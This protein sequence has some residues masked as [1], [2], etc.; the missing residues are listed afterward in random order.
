MDMIRSRRAPIMSTIFEGKVPVEIKKNDKGQWYGFSFDNPAENA[1]VAED[2]YPKYLALHN[3]LK[4]AHANMTLV[5][6][7][8]DTG[9]DDVATVPEGSGKTDTA[10]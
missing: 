8:E 10:F 7:H 1:W 3:M 6:D 5:V 2:V 9:G 4:D